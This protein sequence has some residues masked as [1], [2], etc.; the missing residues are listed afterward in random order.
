[1]RCLL[2]LTVLS[3]AVGRPV[4]ADGAHRLEGSDEEQ[5]LLKVLAQ[6]KFIRAREQAEKILKRDT[7]SIIARYAL[8]MAFFEEEANLPRALY[9]L[10]RCERLLLARYG[11]VPSDEQARSWHRKLLLAQEDVLGEMDRRQEQLKVLERHDALY[12]PDERHRRIW[13]LM[14]LHRFAEARRIATELTQS[15]EVRMRIRGYNGLLSVELEQGRPQACFDLAI[16]AVQNTGY[17]SCVLTLNA[18]EA[19][20]AVFRFDEVERLAQ[21]SLQAPD[22]DCPSSAHIHLTNLYLMRGDFQR[23]VAALRALREY[24]V[25]RR[26]RQQFEAGVNAWLLRILYALGQFDKASELAQRVVRTP[27][28]VGLTSFSHELMVLIHY[29]DHYATLRAQLEQLAER[30]SARSVGPRLKLWAERRLLELEAWSARRKAAKLL[31]E[32]GQLEELLRPYLKPLPPWRAASVD[33]VV[34]RG[35]VEQA[36]RQI[37]KGEKMRDKVSPYFAAYRGE[38]AF[39]HGELGL[40]RKLGQQALEGLDRNEVLLRLRVTAWIGATAYRQGKRAEAQAAFH[41]V[42]D[43]WPTALRI[44]SLPV[45]VKFVSDGSA[46]ANDLLERLRRSPRLVAGSLEL[47]VRVSAKG[48]KPSICMFGPRKRRYACVEADGKKTEEDPLALLIDRFHQAA[49]SPRIDLT[50]ADINSLDGSAVRGRADDVLKQVL[51]Q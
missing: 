3:L 19:A 33:R 7:D 10:R 2:L 49:F 37:A 35:V 47:T 21:R 38:M 30:A 1:M 5:A 14:K 23:A 8:A 48:G 17:R 13:P 31:G 36:L 34:G 51:G 43:R 25:A 24:G 42:I 9:H 27:D 41:R 26:H 44:L 29:L 12:K 40:A 15:S 22:K 18:A 20:F 45:P 39:R 11:Q 28:R 6:K 46:L 32:R 50:Q 16:K 4:A